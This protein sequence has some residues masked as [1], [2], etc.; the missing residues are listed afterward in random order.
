MKPTNIP[1][2]S[3]R[4]VNTGF[5]WQEVYKGSAGFTMELTMQSTFRVSAGSADV[6]VTIDGVLA[7]TLRAN[8]V[9]YFNVGAGKESD[10]KSTITVVI[11]AADARVQV[12]LE[13]DPGRRSR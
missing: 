1:S 2:G 6:A 12:A 7:M 13:N 11:G 5:V 3:Q 4:T 9:E 8:E 10:S